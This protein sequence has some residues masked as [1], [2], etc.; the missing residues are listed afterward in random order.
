M[1]KLLQAYIATPTEKARAKLQAY[2]NAHMMAF[3]FATPD[4]Q[5][6]IIAEGFKV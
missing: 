2:L 5:K 3:C 1:N 6:F 4:E